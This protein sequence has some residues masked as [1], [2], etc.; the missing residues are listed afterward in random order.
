VGD[1]RSFRKLGSGGSI[2]YRRILVAVDGSPA[3][4]R[5]LHEAVYLAADQR[6]EL[7]ILHVVDA[8][9]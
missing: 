2:V 7:E 4:Q 1:S 3:A 8:V 9:P 6:A 5:A